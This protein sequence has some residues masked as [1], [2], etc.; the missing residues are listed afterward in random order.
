MAAAKGVSTG[1]AS[2][3]LLAL[4]DRNL[5]R[6]IPLAGTIHESK[7]KGHIARIKPMN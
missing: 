4:A 1:E 3:V 6:G 7:G 2:R 5:G